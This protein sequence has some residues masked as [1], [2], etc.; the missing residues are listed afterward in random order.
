MEGTLEKL[1]QSKPGLFSGSGAIWKSYY[2]IL[3]EDVLLFTETH[4]RKKILGKLHMQ[5]SKILRNE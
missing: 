3:H 1:D 5:I 4:D 2:F